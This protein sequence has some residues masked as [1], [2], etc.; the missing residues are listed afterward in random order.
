MKKSFVLLLLVLALPAAL[1]AAAKWPVAGSPD[2][3][4][5][6]DGIV[7]FEGRQT[8]LGI[9]QTRSG[10]IVQV[11][12]S[13]VVAR[14]MP[15]GR[16]D[17]SLGGDGSVRT[18]FGNRRISTD[19]VLVDRKGR[20][21]IL[22]NCGKCESKVYSWS[23]VGRLLP[24][25]RPD[26]TFA[27]KGLSTLP[28]TRDFGPGEIAFAPGGRIVAVGGKFN[29]RKQGSIIV[30]YRRNG[31]LDR[32][33]ADG[34]IRL[35]KPGSGI[36]GM[37]T[38]AVDKSGRIV[39]GFGDRRRT[40]QNPAARTRLGVA[41]LLPDGRFDHSF[42]GDGIASV[43]VP[44]MGGGTVQ[45]LTIDRRGRVVGVGYNGNLFAPIFRF[46]R[47]GHLDRSFARIGID[48]VSWTNAESVSVDPKGRILVLGQDAEPYGDPSGASIHR[49]R[50]NGTVDPNFRYRGSLY[51]V[52][53]HFVDS[54]GRIVASGSIYDGPAVAR[55]RN[56]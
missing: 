30:K 33:F 18:I 40:D 20:I 36:T 49:Y 46:T 1:A 11:R 34:G 29:V 43:V 24:N 42:S 28:R 47:N 35:F 50:P 26:R 56:P 51:L 31:H 22:G 19:D 17:L 48:Q 16:K 55:I 27:H 21:V 4:F 25:G 15:N 3:S 10:R 13:G 23:S 52:R 54:R 45:D 2:K 38:V 44:H 5:S 7:S 12:S 41:R 14:Y 39:V 8:G 53:D 6:G 9:A 32:S 37:N